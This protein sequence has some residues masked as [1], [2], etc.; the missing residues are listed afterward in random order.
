MTEVGP[1]DLDIRGQKGPPPRNLAELA[2]RQHGVVA[3]WQLLE[4]GFGRKAIDH[5]VM[6]GRLHV[7]HRGVYAV[8][9][10]V[11][12]WRGQVMA[13]VLACGPE[14]LASHR[15]AGMIWNLRRSSS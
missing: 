7:L 15:E 3:R 13:A 4:M 9:H 14:A 2:N 6:A 11:L 10:T 1:F 12:G 8:G 5:W